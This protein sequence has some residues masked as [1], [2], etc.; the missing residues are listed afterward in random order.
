MGANAAGLLT[1]ERPTPTFARGRDATVRTA[2]IGFAV[3]ACSVG[4]W[5]G[6][7]TQPFPIP[8]AVT[9]IVIGAATR[10]FGI[11]LPGK[12]FTSFV[13]GVGVA[14]VIALGWAAGAIV[15]ATG[16]FVGDAVFRRL[17]LR[18]A[19]GNAGH[20]ATASVISGA[21]YGYLGGTTTA[22][23]F[24]A[25]A[26]WRMGAFIALFVGTLNATF[27]LQLRLSQAIA[28]VDPRL[29]ARW[30]LAVAVLGTLIALTALHLSY[31]SWPLAEGAAILTLLVGLTVLAHWLVRR[32]S[33]GESLNLVHNLSQAISARIELTRAF[34][35]IQRLSRSLVPWEHM[36]VARYDDATGEFVIVA[37]TSSHFPP[38]TRFPADSALTGLA[39]RLGKPVTDLLLSAEQRLLRNDPGSEILVPLKL[40]NR[41]VGIWSVRHSMEEMYR[42]HDAD[43]LGFASPQLALSLSLDQTVQPVLLTSEEMTAHVQS[44]T[45]SAQELHAVSEESAASVRRLAGMSRMLAETLSRGAVEAR[46]AHAAATST[47]NEGQATS[48]RG[49]EMLQD[50]RAVRQATAEALDRLTA[51]SAVVA[52]SAAEVSRLEEISVAV[53]QFGR[54]I[55]SLADQ[56][57]LLALNA[58][59]EA[60]RAGVHGR[61][62]AVVAQEIR[63]L[64]DRSAVEAEGVER[65]VRDTR[66]AL[67]RVVELIERSRSEMLA[68]AAASG[69][70]LDEL[71][72]IV[73]AAEAVAAAG[74]RIVQT[75]RDSATRSAAMSSALT[76]AEQDAVSSAGDTEAVASAITEQEGGVEAL[77]ESATHLANLA[78]RLAEVVA[79]LRESAAA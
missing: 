17:P 1:R 63:T 58:A 33:A 65:A 28:W 23:A 74:H 62:F 44:I 69:D 73:T 2:V 75:A 60:A 12:G 35:D 34:A 72:R 5:A 51:A 22:D 76:A 26:L 61:G 36:G 54:T 21:A 41:L 78:E 7:Y 8:T 19:F 45:A 4:I 10:Y 67:D 49:N 18:N 68:V 43:L 57:G 40:G 16:C 24:G 14:A 71:D 11:P 9:L 27:Y 30:E 29:T 3:A 6:E 32:G 37:E 13:M 53:Q 48:D 56:T 46:T 52:E 64:A 31:S 59:V 55:T 20:I 79:R 25:D 47:V 66:A 15:C 77:N 50:A 38:G 39:V 70:W 42:E